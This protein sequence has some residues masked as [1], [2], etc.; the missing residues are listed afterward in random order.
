[1]A[2][3]SDQFLFETGKFKG[4]GWAV[5][6]MGKGALHTAELGVKW[7]YQPKGD[8]GFKW[9]TCKQATTLSVLVHGRFRMDSR[10]PGGPDEHTLIL[11]QPGSYVIFGPRFEHRSEALED[12]LFLTIHWPSLQDDCRAVEE[13]AVVDSR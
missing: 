1:M 8:A 11:E 5:G 6:H 9:R 3:F 13:T 10:Q 7:A 12:S 4:D 2:S